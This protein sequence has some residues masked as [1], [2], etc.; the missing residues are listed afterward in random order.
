MVCLG[1]G[2]RKPVTMLLQVRVRMFSIGDIFRLPSSG[3]F[4]IK[5]KNFS[6]ESIDNV[7]PVDRYERCQ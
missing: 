4:G 2:A 7:R 6:F 3:I 5:W 1:L